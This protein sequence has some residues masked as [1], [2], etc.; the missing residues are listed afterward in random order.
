MYNKV[1]KMKQLIAIVLFLVTIAIGADYKP[2]IFEN[3]S[4]DEVTQQASWD[5]LM[6]YKMFGATGIEFKGSDIIIPDKSGWFGT[7]IGDFNMNNANLRH[8]VGGPILIGGNMYMSNQY[9][10]LSTG[11][12]RVT[13]NVYA[14]QEGFKD[15]GS[16]INGNQCI[17]GTTDWKYV[18]YIPTEKRFFGSN[19]KACPPEVPQIDTTLRIP[20][21]L[22]AVDSNKLS[23]I[24]IRNGETVY[25]DIPPVEGKEMYDI[26]IPF[27]S[28]NN[29]GHLY[30]RMQNGGRL[31][32][33]FLENGLNN[34][35]AGNSIQ[36][37]YMDNA[38]TF[39][40]GKWSGNG[41]VINNTDYS[42]NLLFY[43][44]KSISFPAM[45]PGDTIQ[46]TFI[47]TD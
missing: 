19:Y 40:N 33:V 9:D 22:N 35:I 34:F 25:I 4:K 21:V 18:K 24:T 43:T 28:F 7:S 31:T 16:I 8:H 14:N 6:K 45:N 17:A 29:S 44:T 27:I 1:N 10:T 13:G 32:R 12:V 23:A 15:G 5:L 39:E 2:F 37:I 20:T 30:F 46:G 42:G 3:V 47:T 41:S 11:P 36:V 26:Y 38:S